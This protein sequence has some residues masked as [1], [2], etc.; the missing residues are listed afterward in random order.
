MFKMGHAG[1]EHSAVVTDGGRPRCQDLMVNSG[2]ICAGN[3]VG[4]VQS[5]FAP[6][7]SSIAHTDFPTAIP[8]AAKHGIPAFDKVPLARRPPARKSGTL[9]KNNLSSAEE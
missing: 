1:T 6:R 4:L 5:K 3:H 9:R 2:R 8:A 7:F